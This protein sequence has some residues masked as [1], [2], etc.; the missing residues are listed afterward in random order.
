MNRILVVSSM[1]AGV[2]ASVGSQAAPLSPDPGFLVPPAALAGLAS[3]VWK[4]PHSMPFRLRDRRQHRAGSDR[5][6]FQ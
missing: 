1:I 6:A 4:R 2:A 5:H 3:R